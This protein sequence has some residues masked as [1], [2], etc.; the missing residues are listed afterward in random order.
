MVPPSSDHQISAIV[1]AAGM[2]SRMGKPKLLLPWNDHSIIE[3]TVSQVLKAGYEGVVVV[4]GANWEEVRERLA[5]S[6]VKIARN[7]NFRGGL[8]GSLKAGIAFLDSPVSAFSIVLAD[9]PQVTAKVHKLVMA[10]FRKQKK[11][12]C[13]PRFDGT[14]GHPVIFSTDYK[15]Q[16]YALSGD[17]GARGV[18]QDNEADVAYLDIKAPEIV[19]SINTPAEYEAHMKLVKA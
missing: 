15:P 5:D 3:E 17:S 2:S 18:V 9:Q 16:I 13:V 8:S 10:N 6:P 7:L 11:G 1:L 12:I 4:L 14:I 19:E